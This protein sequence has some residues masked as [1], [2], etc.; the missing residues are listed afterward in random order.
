[1]RALRSRAQL[2][3]KTGKLDQALASYRNME[4]GGAADEDFRLDLAFLWKNKG[5]FKKAEAEVLRYIGARP[6]DR[7][8]RLL[9][10]DLYDGQGLTKQAAQTLR[11]LVEA[12]P[13]DQAAHRRL[14]QIYRSMGEP[15]KAIETIE[16]LINILEASGSPEDIE[17]LS[18]T[19][20]EYEQAIS[21]HEKDF[22]EEREKTIRRLREMTVDTARA[23]KEAA[24]EDTLMVEELESSE[25]DT[26]PIINVGGMEPIL[27]VEESP[28]VLQLTEEQEPVEEE[29]VSID[30]ERPPNLVNLLQ[31]QELYEENPALQTFQPPPQFPPQPP[32]GGGRGAPGLPGQPATPVFAPSVPVPVT[33]P[34]APVPVTAPAP[35]L[36]GAPAAPV[37]APVA[38]FPFPAPVAPL[39]ASPLQPQGDSALAS[40]LKESVQAQQKMV[41][42]LFDELREISRRLDQ[43]PQVMP[44]TVSVAPP[45]PSAPPPPYMRPVVLQMPPQPAYG[46]PPTG[47]RGGEA[48]PETGAPVMPDHGEEGLP[49]YAEDVPEEESETEAE[50]PRMVPAPELG[51]EE[52]PPEELE[53]VEEVA[54]E[55]P[56]PLEPVEE[57]EPPQQRSREPEEDEV[58]LEEVPEE[59][60]AGP[61]GVPSLEQPAPAAEVEEAEPVEEP[62][63]AA[64]ERPPEPSEKPD[65]DLRKQL[66]DYINS[67]KDKL[68]AGPAPAER[69]RTASGPGELLDYLGKLSEYLPERQ[70]SRFRASKER[71][72]MEMVKSRLAGRRGL[73]D[74]IR[75][76]YRPL[77]PRDSAPLTRP[78]V[79]DTFSYLKDLSAWHPDKA[80]GD[81]LRER[82]DSIIARIGRP[83]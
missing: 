37:A 33:A 29:M 66:R 3:T 12:A 17:S 47:P 8:A 7:Q 26:V 59:L 35:P 44:V 83:G 23:E 52:P 39:P 15:Q 67:V 51:Q 58:A 2:L 79:L 34:S 49:R 82:L 64:P 68:D 54:E 78:H 75:E 42:K 73:R 69:Q 80:V 11:E 31:G 9:L 63:P 1:M 36:P 53:A 45:V 24:D 81:A 5:D 6:A 76:N 14:A 28:E 61:S 32:G 55:V 57:E 65:G 40:S 16:G 71:L 60:M 30:D 41:D 13:D 48:P 56:E 25:E 10:S 62:V 38:P 27:A 22:R 20:E 21:E 72:A 74:R 43:R 4:A 77:A 18:T 70:K 19:I 46:G 50:G